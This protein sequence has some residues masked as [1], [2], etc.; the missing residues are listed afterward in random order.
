[1]QTVDHHRTRLTRLTRLPTLPT[2]RRGGFT[3]VELLVVIGIIALL[4]SML[5][6]SLNS[7]RRSADKVRSLA[8]FRELG[9]MITLYVNDYNLRLPG[10]IVNGQ[11]VAMHRTPNQ[12][13]FRLRDY[14][15][16]EHL[17]NR[18]I[19]EPLAPGAFIARVGVDDLFD[20]QA[21]YAVNN[22]RGSLEGG[23]GRIKPWG[24]PGFPGE[25]GVPKPIT[26]ILDSSAQAAVMDYDEV[27]LRPVPGSPGTWGP[28]VGIGPSVL[29]MPLYDTRNYLF[30]DMHAETLPLNANVPGF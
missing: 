20:Y 17:P 16:I 12:I 29:D 26:R 23:T 30:F 5:L 6:P 14:Y 2:P 28:P 7:A 18:E 22:V 11:K 21:L 19:V 27:L 4:I 25:N 10:P 1:M 3:L 9:N 15:D 24:Y 8:Q 13:A